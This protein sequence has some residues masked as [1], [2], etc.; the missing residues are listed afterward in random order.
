[1]ERNDIEVVCS[2]VECSSVLLTSPLC[3]LFLSQTWKMIHL[4]ELYVV[5]FH[6]D[7]WLPLYMK[8]AFLA[9]SHSLDV[10]VHTAQVHLH[11]NRLQQVRNDL[12]SFGL[13]PCSQYSNA[14]DLVFS[15]FKISK[16]TIATNCIEKERRKLT[17]KRKIQPKKLMFRIMYEL[18][19]ALICTCLNCV[20]FYRRLFIDFIWFSSIKVNINRN[21]TFTWNSHQF[22]DFFFFDPSVYE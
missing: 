2:F 18:H 13:K 22:T 14:C 16:V 10:C 20:A 19:F 5:M 11:T 9:P 7:K 12:I 4:F 21:L 15:S 6:D 8:Y 17:K 1:M 3:R